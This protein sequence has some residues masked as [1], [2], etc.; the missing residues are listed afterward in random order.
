MRKE[1]AKAASPMKLLPPCR[2]SPKSFALRPIT[3][4]SRTLGSHGHRKSIRDSVRRV[5]SCYSILRLPRSLCGSSQFC[6]RTSCCSSETNQSAS[7]PCC[8]CI[9][10]SCILVNM[11]YQLL[12]SS[13][14]HR[15][16]L[17]CIRH[18]SRRSI[19]SAQNTT[20]S[21]RTMV[22]AAHVS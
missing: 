14:M 21:R 3:S 15:K 19:T 9:T 5:K 7:S 4:S 18:R 1:D 16:Q 20:L 6:M 11:L 8:L 10:S 12:G 22:R 13:R 2:Q 17:S